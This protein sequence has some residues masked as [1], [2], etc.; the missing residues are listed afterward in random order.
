MEILKVFRG[1]LIRLRSTWPTYHCMKFPLTCEL[2]Y[3]IGFQKHF[4]LYKA[5]E[6]SP[7]RS[8]WAFRTLRFHQRVLSEEFSISKN[9]MASWLPQNNGSCAVLIWQF[10]HVPA[11][12]RKRRS[13]SAKVVDSAGEGSKCIN[14]SILN[15]QDFQNRRESFAGN[16][17]MFSFDGNWFETNGM[18]YTFKSIID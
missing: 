7:E 9:D 1:K 6:F 17:Q 4:R 14:T 3:L 18:F 5:C 12:L 13:T 10:L 15:Y 2:L 8:T 11:S 16:N